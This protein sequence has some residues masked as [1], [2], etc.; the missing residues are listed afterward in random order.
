[1]T[2]QIAELI[3]ELIEPKGVGVVVDGM[4]MCVMMRGAKKDN[5]HMRTSALLGAFRDQPN[6]QAE[7]MNHIETSNRRMFG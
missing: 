1:M 7:F 5:A 2:N 6:T 3:D 4:H